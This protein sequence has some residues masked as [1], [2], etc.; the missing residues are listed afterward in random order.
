[1]GLANPDPGFIAAT[2]LVEAQRCAFSGV[3]PPQR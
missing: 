1:M 3:A 2:T